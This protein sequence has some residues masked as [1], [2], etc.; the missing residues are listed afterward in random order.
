MSSDFI[1]TDTDTFE[2]WLNTDLVEPPVLEEM[3]TQC[4]VD[5]A[6]EYNSV[7]S[8]PDGFP[9]CTKAAVT[10]GEYVLPRCGVTAADGS[11]RNCC[12]RTL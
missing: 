10:S 1:P 7:S 6:F 12:R 5:P 9:S 2:E 11:G 8:D 4:C 3:N